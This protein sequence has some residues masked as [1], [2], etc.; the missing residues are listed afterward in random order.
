MPATSV[1]YSADNEKIFEFGKKHRNQICW[2][3]L[4]R[5]VCLA[6]F[7]NLSGEMEMWD[8]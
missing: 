1:L 8:L 5:F 7:G 6:G 2:G 3:R 4:G